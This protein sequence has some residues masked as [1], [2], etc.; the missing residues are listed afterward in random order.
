MIV[1]ST[2]T[3]LFVVLVLAI[4]FSCKKDNSTTIDMGYNYMP[5]AVGT[6]VIYNVTEI[7]HDT[8]ATPR[9][10]TLIYQIME[11][12]ESHFIDNEGRESERI[13]RFK[14]D[15]ITGPWIIK[16][17]WYSTVTTVRAEKIE[18]NETYIKLAFMP[19]VGKRWDGNALNT[20]NEWEYVY[21]EV[22]EATIYGGLPFDSTVTVLQR[23]VFNLVEYEQAT[24]VY[25]RG[26]GLVYKYFKDLT[27]HNFDT[28]QIENGK[29][30]YQTVVDYGN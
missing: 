21:S 4:L 13:E 12:I 30:L 22:D 26:V 15:S 16:D 8:L 18:E 5:T 2:R 19:N 25:A 9:H 14:R 28:L 3:Y 24:E 17:V 11:V 23:E 7:T 10:D 29:E 1:N 20:Q 6:W 27:I